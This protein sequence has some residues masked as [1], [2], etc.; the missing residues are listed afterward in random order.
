MKIF[1]ALIG[2]MLLALS[3]ASFAQDEPTETVIIDGDGTT[4]IVKQIQLET[5][6]AF[7]CENPEFDS[8]DIDQDGVLDDGCPGLTYNPCNYGNSII[9]AYINAAYTGQCIED[10]DDGLVISP[11]IQ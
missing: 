9:F 8:F 10:E 2:A 1:M 7:V 3:S 11:G 6:P 5:V 4:L